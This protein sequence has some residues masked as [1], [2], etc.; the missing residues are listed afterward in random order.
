MPTID[1]AGLHVELPGGWE[2]EIYTHPDPLAADSVAEDPPAAAFSAQGVAPETRSRNN[3]V[4]VATFPLPAGRADYGNGAVQLMGPDDIFVALLEHTADDAGQALFT[5]E[6]LPRLAGNDFRTDVLHRTLPGHSGCQR[7]FH[8]GD[9]AFCLYVVLGNHNARHT[10]VD[11]V[12]TIL[13]GL[14]ID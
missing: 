4:H 14:R 6:G 5:T 8:V 9:R 1:S 13:D 12:N 3:I 7:F 11:R 10:M 2:G